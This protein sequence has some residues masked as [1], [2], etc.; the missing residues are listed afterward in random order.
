MA[1][2]EVA[3]EKL[4]GDDVDALSS[5]SVFTLD[6]PYSL[7]KRKASSL[8][9]LAGQFL[10]KLLA[11]LKSLA[12]IIIAA[13]SLLTG[14]MDNCFGRFSMKTIRLPCQPT[15]GSRPHPRLGPTRTIK[16]RVICLLRFSVTPQLHQEQEM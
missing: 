12:P 9:F 5:T 4:V 11:K 16:C 13:S 8:T 2:N 7:G 3:M 15:T 14:S 1:P 10:D 6:V